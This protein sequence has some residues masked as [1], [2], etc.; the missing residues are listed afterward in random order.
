MAWFIGI[1]EAGYGPNLGP[2]VV[3]ASVW[4]V[5]D[6]RLGDDVYAMAVPAVTPL[7]VRGRPPRRQHIG[8]GVQ[9][10][11]V[12]VADSKYVYGRCGGLSELERGVLAALAAAGEHPATVEQ[13]WRAVHVEPWCPPRC[14]VVTGRAPIPVSPLAEE[15]AQLGAWLRQTLQKSQ[16]ALC[17][18][19]AR[20]A[21]PGEFNQLLRVCGNK[22]EVLQVL[23]LRLVSGLRPWMQEGPGLLVCDRQGGRTRYA[24]MA[25]QI[26]GERPIRVL[27]ERPEA[28]A[29]EW[30][31]A[32][33]RIELRF[34]TGGERHL[35]VALASMAA[36]YLRELAMRDFNA[37]W[38][39]R[40]PGLTPTAGY[41]NDAGR[42]MDC[43]APFMARLGIERSELWRE[44]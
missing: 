44:R 22:A 34:E 43:I 3:A 40:V 20:A 19:R 29:Y 41:P 2:L 9:Q 38:H 17:A 30:Q 42:F 8:D 18:M 39:A 6:A 16:L 23:F 32:S 27:Y 25:Q 36:K 21:Y 11:P 24:A 5:P 1:D 12:L 37:W 14:F 33:G 15:L 31:S 26:A 28:S 35:P 7:A 10:R 13:V 4:R